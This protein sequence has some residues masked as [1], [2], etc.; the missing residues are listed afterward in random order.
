MDPAVISSAA[1]AAAGVIL[2]IADAGSN[3]R[4]V[5]E[6]LAEGGAP[7]TVVAYGTANVI[8][9]RAACSAG[10]V[11]LLELPGAD[12]AAAAAAGAAATAAP[13]LVF[14][15]GAELRRGWLASLIAALADAG[16]GVAGAAPA[17]AGEA[18]GFILSAAPWTMRGFDL[19]PLA[20]VLT[21][22]AVDVLVRDCFA[23]SRAAFDAV[24]GF[25]AS[26]GDGLTVVDYCLRVAETGRRIVLEPA[27]AIVRSIAR[28]AGEQAGGAAFAARWRSRAEPHEN[29]WPER[30]GT[31]VRRE[32][33]QTGVLLERVPVPRIVAIVHGADT[34]APDLA[35]RL[36]GGRLVPDE[37]VWLAGRDAFDAAR[38]HTEVRG[39]DL[40]AFV[41]ADTRLAA[42][43]LNELLN[44]LERAPDT[45]AAAVTS[46]KDERMPAAAD[47]RCTLVAPRRIPQHLRI[48]PAASLDAALAT[49]LGAA[50]DA[51]RNIAH[52]A[53]SATVI[54]PPAISIG[55]A[56]PILR[57]VGDTFTTI[58]MLSWNAPEYTE[59]AVD[60]IRAN[61]RS[62]YEIVVI[63]NGSRPEA[64]ARVRAI[65]GVRLI[66]NAVNTGFAFACNQGLAAARGTHVVLLNNDV[67]VTAGWLDAL[68]AVQR[69]NP[70]VGCSAPRSNKIASLQQI[71]VPY[72]DLAELPAFAAQRALALRGRWMHEFKVVGFCMCLDRRVVAEIGGLDPRFGAGNFEDDDYCVRIRSAGYDIAVC[73]DSFIHHF[74]S[75]SFTQNGVD[76]NAAF[77]RNR[78]IFGERWNVAFDGNTYDPRAL[79]RRG[80]ARERDFVPLPPPAGVG[81]EWVHAQ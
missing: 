63:D 33:Y 26:F 34:A 81:A 2:T 56:E 24:G 47:A 41:R 75:V 25:D 59:L 15:D 50:V 12:F 27:A 49:W 21:R 52:A 10:N 18:G 4:A 22:T 70:G 39:A 38:A 29:F 32:F 16:G 40:I 8:S 9:V 69:Q 19:E 37:I 57:D 61:T 31:L 51:G 30:T 65:A 20:D 79:S 11:P 60:S 72:R 67:V 14:V 64:L 28:A 53:R 42:D 6:S 58:V 62:P 1:D 7:I 76:Y 44:V 23:T 78:A 35:E 80:F 77:E 45:V 36:S 48:E 73:E 17:A 13:A 54:G 71:D 46:D 5:V 68:L 55:A 66:E 74:G 3:F 43:W